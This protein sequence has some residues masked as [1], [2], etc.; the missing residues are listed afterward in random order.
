MVDKYCVID[1]EMV[2]TEILSY[3]VLFSCKRVKKF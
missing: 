3:I 1:L 2:C